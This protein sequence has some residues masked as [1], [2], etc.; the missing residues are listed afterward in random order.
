MADNLTTIGEMM[1]RLERRL[2]ELERQDG[3][4][5]FGEGGTSVGMLEPLV[6]L[7]DEGE[8]E[9]LVADGDVLTAEVEP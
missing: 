2:S 1:A 5:G 8:V 6:A 4:I 9:M 3:G 7:N